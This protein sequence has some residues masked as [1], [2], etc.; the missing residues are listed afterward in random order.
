MIYPSV[1]MP[2]LA[3]PLVV[4]V[5]FLLGLLARWTSLPP[6]V[7][8]LAAGFVLH[9]LGQRTHAMIEHAADFGV[10][11]LMF[12]IG[13]K[14][15]LST[16]ARPAVWAGATVHMVATVVF[17]AVCLTLFGAVGLSAFAGI[18][19][20]QAL[21][22][23]FS[24]SFSSTVFAVKVLE[25][26]QESASGHGRVAIGILI[27]QDIL[28]VLFLAFSSG[29]VPSI[30]AL[31]L[32]SLIPARALLQRVMTGAGHGSSSCSRD[33]SWPWSLG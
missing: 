15:R 29:K 5:T 32:V 14:L 2:E 7:G 9:A 3:L 8:F 22:L 33:C 26:R 23:G 28:A 19:I 18:E 21:L 13:L 24:L 4:T 30:Y 10:T 11:L 20:E 16:L 25:S 27:M 31:L 12:T 6:M 17:V 1:P